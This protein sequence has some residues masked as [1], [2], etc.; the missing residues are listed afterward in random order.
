MKDLSY[1]I[2]VAERAQAGKAGAEG[3]Q[4]A[5]RVRAQWSRRNG[6]G[7]VRATYDRQTL[8][9]L[10]FVPPCADWAARVA[11]LFEGWEGDRHVHG[12]DLSD[13]VLIG[14]ERFGV[15]PQGVY[16][17]AARVAAILGECENSIAF[18][19]PV[20]H[21]KVLFHGLRLMEE[22]N[23]LFD[24]DPRCLLAPEETALAMTA[25]CIHDL[26]HDGRGNGRGATYEPGRLE[27][28]A[29]D[30]ARPWLHAAGLDTEDLL[31][32]EAILLSTEVTPIG[33]ACAAAAQMRGAYAYHFQG[34]DV[35]EL[36]GKLTRL[37][38]RRDLARLGMLV[39]AADVANSAGVSESMSRHE[40][41]L[42]L[43]ECGVED[44]PA[45]V[46]PA[47]LEGVGTVLEQFE[48]ARSLYNDAR[49]AILKGSR[50]P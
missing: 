11:V 9:D 28:R 8:E 18:H 34:M 25:I 19:N 14:L 48:P 35:C 39:H 29:F 43:R 30:L 38:G 21:R 41:A 42:F 4:L 23:R 22:N 6:P 40:T 5:E 27:Q 15:E 49:L 37:H 47:F 12:P 13:L 1:I 44:A 2:K 7:V 17:Q 32:I 36:S 33:E 26:M 31:D 3:L 20:H 24:D 46:L 50:S 10:L 45:D 16:A